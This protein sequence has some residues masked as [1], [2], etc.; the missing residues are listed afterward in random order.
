MPRW[1][2]ALFGEGYLPTS[3]RSPGCALHGVREREPAPGRVLR[4]APSHARPSLCP[5]VSGNRDSGGRQTRP[6]HA[7]VWAR[8]GVGYVGFRRGTS[9]YGS[10]DGAD[11]EHDTRQ[12]RMKRL[13]SLRLNSPI[14]RHRQ[15]CGLDARGRPIGSEAPL[16]FADGR[17]SPKT[18]RHAS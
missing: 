17:T 12:S 11:E 6:R 13:P 3:R 5:G 1:A 8:G 10:P 14:A 9:Q 2:C 16:G 7:D 18:S 4:Y 15:A